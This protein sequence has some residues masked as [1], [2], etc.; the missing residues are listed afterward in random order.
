MLKKIGQF[1]SVALLGVAVGACNQYVAPKQVRL[2]GSA[3]L[4]LDSIKAEALIPQA[5]LSDSSIAS[6]R[7]VYA[8]S[9]DDASN[10]R[11]LYSTFT[12]T[13]NTTT[14]FNNLTFYAYHRASTNFGGTAVS[15]MARSDLSS[16]SDPNVARSLR[17]THAMYANG[18]SYEVNPALADFQAISQNQAQTLQ[19]D[20]ILGGVI[21]SN[22]SVLSYGFVATNANTNLREIAPGAKGKVTVAVRYPVAANATLNPT[23]FN[24]TF[25]LADEGTRRVTRSIEESTTSFQNR[26][27]ATGASEA[28]EIGTT[29]VG[30]VLLADVSTSIEGITLLGAAK[31]FAGNTI[32]ALRHGQD[33][34]PFGSARGYFVDVLSGA[35]GSLLKTIPVRVSKNGNQQ[36]LTTSG[37]NGQ[38]GLLNR[39]ADGK[40]LMFSGHNEWQGTGV[41]V[42]SSAPRGVGVIYPDGAISTATRISDAF[43]GS[44]I[45][46]VASDNCSRFWVAGIGG[47]RLVN[48]KSSGSSVPIV[49]GI[50]VFRQIRF[51]N[52]FAYVSMSNST[53]HRLANLTGIPIT[54]LDTPT[55]FPGIALENDF[56]DFAL[57]DLDFA[58][59]GVDT[60]LVSNIGKGIQ[61]YSLVGGQWI[62]NGTTTNCKF[63][64][65]L[66][67]RGG[68][69][70]LLAV[71]GNTIWSLPSVGGYNTSWNPTCTTW[72]VSVAGIY[73]GVSLPPIF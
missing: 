48:L 16:L 49:T 18:L 73:S 47:V 45:G 71:E 32:I 56:Y 36:P 61:K 13:N 64:S 63:A 20:A 22:D 33:N 26:L 35:D 66:L 15:S 60:M 11:W 52:F 38:E 57:F 4:E 59:S 55:A 31:P 24:M 6:L 7:R 67:D 39:S 62:L 46:G 53:T 28:V 25:V 34:S 54:G 70:S 2:F 8:S 43:S 5:A 44:P 19:N 50:E 72:R 10:V 58:T 14:T 68:G 37:L 27:I 12:F 42:T 51:V 17:P 69:N 30:N 29:S 3:Q 40:C 21:N 1:L 41:V 65:S 23:R 9:V